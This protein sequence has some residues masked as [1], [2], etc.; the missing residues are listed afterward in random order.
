MP[1]ASDFGI[2]QLRRH[3]IDVAE[4]VDVLAEGRAQL[5]ELAVA[6][7]VADQ[8]LEA[9]PAL[10]RLA[11][12]QRDVGIVAA[13]RDDVGAGALELGDQ[14]G[15]IGR[16]GRIAL[17]QHDLQALLLGI[18]LVGRRD[19]D[20]VGA[21]LVDDGD[22]DVLRLLAELR[23]GVFGKEAGEG[24]AVLVGVDLRAEDVTC[25]SCP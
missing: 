7:A 17:L 8:H 24:L 13:M 20:A 9:Q 15:K 18:L 16:G 12:E 10:A 23:L 22:L 5:V 14:R 6:G 19:A 11:Q 25:G 4:I 3:R 1:G 21:V 2:E